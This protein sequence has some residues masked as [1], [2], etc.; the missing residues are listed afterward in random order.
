[1]NLQVSLKATQRDYLPPLCLFALFPHVGKFCRPAEPRK[2]MKRGMADPASLDGNINQ[3]F[4][5]P[6]PDWWAIFP[7]GSSDH[8]VTQIFPISLHLLT[9]DSGSNIS[10][11]A[12]LSAPLHGVFQT[13]AY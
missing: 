1:M 4:P 11:F 7:P 5:I 8:R 2:E 6:P 13:A 12:D 3:R 10:L 9:S